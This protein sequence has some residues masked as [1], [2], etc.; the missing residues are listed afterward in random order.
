L[1]TQPPFTPAVTAVGQ[2]RRRLSRVPV[3]VSRLPL[4]LIGRYPDHRA[5][6]AG[7]LQ[8][9][10]ALRAHYNRRTSRFRQPGFHSRRSGVVW[11]ICHISL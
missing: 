4:D 10:H 5:V 8:F 9:S 6:L 7:T 3:M 2:A 1:I 11:R